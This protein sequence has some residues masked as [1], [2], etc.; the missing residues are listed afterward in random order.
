MTTADGQLMTDVTLACL[1]EDF[2]VS[3][4]TC[5]SDSQQG[6]KHQGTLAAA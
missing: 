6:A 1:H 4:F 2:M 5:Q 3:G